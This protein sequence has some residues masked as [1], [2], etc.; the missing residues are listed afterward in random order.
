MVAVLTEEADQGSSRHTQKPKSPWSHGAIRLL[1]AS[2]PCHLQGCE[3]ER[4][5]NQW[6]APSNSMRPPEVD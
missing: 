6:G 3:T 2:S 5:A 1:Q 4:R